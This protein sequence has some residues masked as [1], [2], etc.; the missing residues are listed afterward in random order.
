MSEDQ[1]D[2]YVNQYAGLVCHVRSLSPENLERLRPW[3]NE[4]DLA[5]GNGDRRRMDIAEGVICRIM[6]E[7]NESLIDVT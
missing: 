3:L 6:D 2:M 1:I 5:R 7:I 4:Y